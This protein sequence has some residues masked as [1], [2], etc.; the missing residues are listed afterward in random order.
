MRGFAFRYIFGGV[1]TELEFPIYRYIILHASFVCD[2]KLINV[3]KP[4][5]TS[6]C[7]G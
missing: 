6:S 7:F 2:F 1:K 4:S 5:I 3:I